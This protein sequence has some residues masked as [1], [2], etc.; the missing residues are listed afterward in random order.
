MAMLQKN[1]LHI[2]YVE[3]AIYQYKNSIQKEYVKDTHYLCAEKK[4]KAGQIS[5][6]AG[7]I[8]KN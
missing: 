2:S 4:T 1:K 8:E 3:L 5:A 7:Q 6:T